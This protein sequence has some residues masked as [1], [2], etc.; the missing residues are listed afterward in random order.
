MRNKHVATFCNLGISLVFIWLMVTPSTYRE[1]LEYLGYDAMTAFVDSPETISP[2]VLVDIDDQALEAFGDWPW[3]R[4]RIAEGIEI[5]A[6]GGARAI[7][8]P[9]LMDTPQDSFAKEA[10]AGLAEA[11][12]TSFGSVEDPKLKAFYQTLQDFQEQLAPDRLLVDAITVAGNVVMPVRFGM[13]PGKN[14]LSAESFVE[15][16]HLVSGALERIDFPRSDY[17][18]LPMPVYLQGVR[19]LGH[20]NFFPD[21]DGKLRRSSPVYGFRGK[22]V[23]SFALAL[24]VD[25]LGVP[26][27]SL[28]LQPQN[29]LS[30]NGRRIPLSGEGTFFIRFDNRPKPFERIGFTELLSG[31][32]SGKVFKDQLVIFN[33]C[34]TGLAPRMTTALDSQMPIGELSAHTIQTLLDGRTIRPFPHQ[35]WITLLMITLAGL[36]I[37]FLLP[38]LSALYV[39]IL[40]LSGIGLLSGASIYF[41]RFHGLWFPAVAP[42][43]ELLAGFIITAFIVAPPKTAPNHRGEAAARDIER[44]QGMSFQSQ[45]LLEAAWDKLCGLP[46][47]DD[48]KAILYDLAIDFEKKGAPDKALM[49]YEHI[50]AADA[51][52]KDI[53]IRMTS[54]VASAGTGATEDPTGRPA[55]SEE[56]VAGASPETALRRLGRYELLH[57]IGRGSMGMVYLGQDPRIKRKTAIKT[58]PFDEEYDPADAEE[59]KRKFFREAESAGKLSHPGIV[60]IFDAGEQG[61]LAYI[62]MEYLDGKD[63]RAYVAKGA[64]LPMRKVID[65]TADIAEALSYAHRQGVVHRDIKPANIMLLESGAVKITDFGIARILATSKTRTGV[66]KGTPYYMAPEQITGK[67]V[68]GRCDIFSLGIVLFQLLTGRLPFTASSPGA[69]MSK[70]VRDP[71]PEPKSINPKILTPLVTVIDKALEKEVTNRYQDAGQMAAHLRQIGQKIDTLLAKRNSLARGDGN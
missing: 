56:P 67:K 7:G 2:I 58:Y 10:L 51:E 3:P 52:F 19:R 66:V 38:R 13:S 21:S 35:R 26:E 65:Y 68:D 49:V 17:V 43:L 29:I 53:Q 30:F 46:V 6:A 62:A 48:M 63:L 28:Y 5:A 18:V 40:S 57:P 71:H 11:F 15:R 32:R 42:V 59:M 25:Y 31:T 8:L 9:L 54:L 37:T 14:A 47:D 20:L 12:R 61:G 69:L 16:S 23:A 24:A 44:L 39:A 27:K 22:P 33:L 1:S 70:I 60:T 41:F 34:A 45:G 50:E 64:L 36:F 4:T 55:G